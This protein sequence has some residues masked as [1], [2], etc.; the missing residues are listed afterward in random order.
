MDFLDRFDV[1]VTTH[2]RKIVA[3]IRARKGRTFLVSFSIFI[4]VLSV[5]SLFTVR[6]LIMQQFAADIQPS[7]LSMIDVWVNLPNDMDVDNAAVLATLNRQDAVGQQFDI[8][9]GIERVEGWVYTPIAFR[10]V[11]DDEFIEGELRSYA[12]PLDAVQIEPMRLIAGGAWPAPGQRQ[13][14]LETRMADRYGFAVGDKIVL[15]AAGAD[16]VDETT[17]TVSG[18]V[19]HPYI[20]RGASP[21]GGVSFGPADGIYVQP[22]DAQALLNSMALTRIVARYENFA[23]AEQNFNAF[24]NLIAQATPYLPVFAVI[25]EPANN[26]QQQTATSL[27]N[28]LTLLAL[29][30]IVDA[31]FLVF[32]IVSTIMVEQ[33]RQ[34]GIMT[35]LGASGLDNFIIYIGTAFVYGFIGTL[36]ALP[37]GIFAGYL[38]TLSIAPLLDILIEGFRWS[39]SAVIIGA[40]L[41]LSVPVIA[42]II[43]VYHGIRVTIIEAITD[44]GIDTSHYGGRAAR[45]IA[46][47]PLPINARQAIANLIRKRRRPMVTG[48]SLMLAMAAF[49]GVISVSIFFNAAFAETFGRFNSQFLI[50]P[51]RLQPFEMMQALVESVEGVEAVAPGTFVTVQIQGDYINFIGR[52]NRIASLSLEPTANVYDFE[53]IAGEGWSNDPTRSGVVITEP[54]ANRL[55]LEVGDSI[56]V[57]VSGRAI[58]P[59]II[60]IQREAFFDQFFLRWQEM[61][62][63]IGLTR[64]APQPNQTIIMA[65]MAERDA[66]VPVVGLDDV[67]L[68]IAWGRPLL[69]HHAIITAGFAA[70]ENL[71]VGDVMQLTIGDNTGTFT[72][73][74]VIE[75]PPQFRDL[76]P[77]GVALNFADLVAL[78]GDAVGGEPIPNGYFVRLAKPNPTVSDVDAVIARV[79]QA[80]LEQGVTGRFQNQLAQAEQLNA[81]VN[82]LTTVLLVAA[83]LIAAV[84]A[85]ALLT[86]LSLSVFERQKEIGIMRSIGADSLTVAV[87]FFLEGLIV[88]LLAWLLAIPLSYVLALT[89][90]DTF[91][92]ENIAFRYPPSAL[93]IGFAGMLVLTT[94]ASFVPALNAARKTV[95]EVIRYQ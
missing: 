70:D 53:Y 90:I 28:V 25:D 69:G 41:G 73:A 43:P 44:F 34:I 71:A 39:S 68:S 88:G 78:M 86:T 5:V 29:V 35:S 33:R 80:M 87:Q 8:L 95:A 46:A 76:I 55:G 81:V 19:F 7:Q 54:M 22:Q 42:A 18:L 24:Q 14:A 26:S 27:G 38:A 57:V 77:E 20:I 47:L 72:V 93:L 51:A 31:G 82:Q 49:M 65:R 91:G 32:N 83:V 64:N 50:I 1:G 89:V 17:Y 85:V 79:K 84:G 67:G 3:D 37:L 92:L 48:T 21:T 11:D 4:G 61:A 10:H 62:R 36:P 6:D 23:L 94:I 12:T 52:S 45:L 63:L 30:T 40:V 60:G 74:G 58:A 66:D 16:D 59:E 9:N 56:P 15:R 75:I 13:V 2:Q